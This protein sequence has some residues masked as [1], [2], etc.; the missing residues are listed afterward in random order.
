MNSG[1]SQYL[2]KFICPMPADW[3]G[4]FYSRQVVYNIATHLPLHLNSI[5][6][7]MGP[8]HVSLI[9]MQGK[10]VLFFSIHS[11][12]TCTVLCLELGGIH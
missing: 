3:P 7:M 12:K 9:K 1:L 4:Q 10:N 2:E 5:V 6:P 11:S 8:L